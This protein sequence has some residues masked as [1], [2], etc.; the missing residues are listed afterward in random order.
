MN[1][2]EKN[3]PSLSDQSLFKWTPNMLH[4]ALG[5]VKNDSFNQFNWNRFLKLSKISYISYFSLISNGRQC[6]E[7]KQN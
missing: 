4:S 5:V 2:T 6:L 7:S 1:L 3:V